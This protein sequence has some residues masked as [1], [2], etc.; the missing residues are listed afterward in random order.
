MN[1]LLLGA[2]AL[3]GALALGGLAGC[4]GDPGTGIATARGPGDPTGEAE[5]TG[6]PSDLD[7]EERML[8]FAQ[9]MRDNGV[10]MPDPEFDGNGGFGVQIGGGDTSPEEVEQAMQ[11]CREY[12]P[13][14]GEPPGPPDP[15]MQERML[16]FAQC[17]RDN[18]VEAFP[19]PDGA[20]MRLDRAVGED[21][22]F[23]AA[24]EKCAEEFLPGAPMT[25]RTQG[26][27]A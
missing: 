25:R 26:A 14:G 18:G 17:M 19:D 3:A 10:D 22:D 7:M 6:G 12:A 11:A 15:E 9:C 21:P 13:N 1:R 16:K 20:M 24:Q 27:G 8:K 2:V 23:E 5:P 4:G